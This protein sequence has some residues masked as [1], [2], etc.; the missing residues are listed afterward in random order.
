MSSLPVGDGAML[1]EGAVGTPTYATLH[2]GLAAAED[3]RNRDDSHAALCIFGDLRER[4]TEH[5]APYLRAA[6]VLSRLHRF[7]EAEQLLATG[8]GAFPNDPGFAI[9]R[10]WLA[11]RRGDLAV[12]TARGRSIR[13]SPPDHHVGH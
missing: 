12:P 5:P 11:Y 8:A 9:E 2:D 13:E 3:A 6:A 1:E 10:A 4:F 7:D